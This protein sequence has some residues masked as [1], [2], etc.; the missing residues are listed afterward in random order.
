MND[1]CWNETRSCQDPAQPLMSAVTDQLTWEMLPSTCSKNKDIGLK[2]KCWQHCH[3]SV[4]HMYELC[5]QRLVFKPRSCFFLTSTWFTS[6]RRDWRVGTTTHHRYH[7][8]TDDTVVRV[9]WPAWWILR[10]TRGYLL[11]FLIFPHS[12]GIFKDFE[13]K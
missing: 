1:S 12:L 3:L 13:F 8:S 2:T 5:C 4:H 7:W 10:I 11:H 9:H 6:L